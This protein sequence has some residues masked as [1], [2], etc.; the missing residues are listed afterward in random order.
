MGT[1]ISHSVRPSVPRPAAP[2]I[3]CGLFARSGS[4]SQIHAVEVELRLARRSP[5]SLGGEDDGDEGNGDGD[6]ERASERPTK[7]FTTPEVAK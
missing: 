4:Q 2:A 7:Y 3:D 1:T 5:G 6:S